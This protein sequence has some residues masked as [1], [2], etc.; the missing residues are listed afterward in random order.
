MYIVKRKNSTLTFQ[1]HAI[2]LCLPQV[3]CTSA[4]HIYDHM[5]TKALKKNH[6]N[7]QKHILEER[8]FTPSQILVASSDLVNSL[9]P[10][11]ILIHN[12][13]PTLLRKGLPACCGAESA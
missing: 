7:Q 10:Q 2:E 13:V 4:I 12:K 9:T 8:F 11:R 6:V 1:T 3:N 5:N